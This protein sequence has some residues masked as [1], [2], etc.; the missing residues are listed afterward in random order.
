MRYA[1]GEKKELS[2][3]SAFANP[4]PLRPDHGAAGLGLHF[5]DL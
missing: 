5:N 2:S 3:S 1:A 4:E